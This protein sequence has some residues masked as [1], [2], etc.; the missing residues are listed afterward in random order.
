MSFE[1]T[2]ECFIYFFV[3]LL[4][5][6]SNEQFYVHYNPVSS[7]IHT[8]SIEMNMWLKEGVNHKAHNRRREH[9]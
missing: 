5:L 9:P 1:L 4:H 6:R 7:A 2:L 3:Y 8:N